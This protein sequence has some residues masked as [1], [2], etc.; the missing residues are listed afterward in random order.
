MEKQSAREAFKVR[1]Q[2]LREKQQARGVKKP[3]LVNPVRNPRYDRVYAE[4]IA[5][6]DSL[7][8]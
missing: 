4:G 3:R 7:A 2:A 1:M 6:L 8:R 5:W